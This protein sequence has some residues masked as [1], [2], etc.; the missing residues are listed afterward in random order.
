MI[1]QSSRSS[2]AK[3]GTNT[4]QSC[5]SFWFEH[6]YSW[7]PTTHIFPLV[8]C[9]H[10]PELIQRLFSWASAPRAARR[11]STSERRSCVGDRSVENNLRLAVLWRKHFRESVPLIFSLSSKHANKTT[12]MALDQMIKMKPPTASFAM[13]S[14]DRINLWNAIHSFHHHIY[15]YYTILYPYL[16]LIG[17]ASPR[18]AAPWRH[19]PWLLCFLSPPSAP[20]GA[21]HAELQRQ[22]PGRALTC[23]AAWIL[24]PRVTPPKKIGEAQNHLSWTN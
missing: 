11:T 23:K 10:Q 20:P 19:R 1:S 7:W 6:S 4:S 5:G 24:S 2:C 18:H 16:S 21:H 9:P 3:Q 14:Q 8:H 15:Q 13:I 22:S 12:E 17:F